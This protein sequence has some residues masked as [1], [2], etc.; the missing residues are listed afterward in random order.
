MPEKFSILELLNRNKIPSPVNQISKYEEIGIED[1]CSEIKNGKAVVPYNP[2]HS[3]EKACIIG[4]RFLVKVNANLGLSP[5]YSDVDNELKKLQK[6]LEAGADCVMDLSTGPKMDEVRKL[7]IENSPVPVGTVPVYEA[8]YRAEE[9]Y[10]KLS[11]KHIIDTIL[12]HA[13][14]GVDFM[15]LHAGLL[16]SH[17]KLAEK[18][19]MGIVSR[20]GMIIARWMMLKNEENPFYTHW[21]EIM[22]ICREYEITVSLGDGLR[23]GCI[24]D[25][26]DTAQFAELEILAELVK[27]CHKNNVQV[28]VE[29]PGH[30]PLNQIE[31]NIRKE[32]ELCNHAPF[33]VLGPVVTDIAPGY[34]HI[35]GA[36]GAAMAGWYGASLLCYVTPSEHLG[37]PDADDVYQGIIAFKIAAHAADIAR[38]NPKAKLK[39]TLMAE[40]RRKFDWQTQFALAI[41][42]KTASKIYCKS[43][44]KSKQ[45]FC[46]MC[47]E[48]FCALKSSE[49]LFKDK[50][51]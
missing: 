26:S 42:G 16:K 13:H 21:D 5:C 29:G 24:E 11:F 19:K 50:K 12:S 25:A 43:N 4:E 30:I 17:V 15:T 48:K 20:G 18:R 35:V 28:M 1:I 41:D 49:E 27:L 51:F 39:D 7:I 47:G 36:I 9:S 23:P 6:A 32:Q 38:K 45:N 10:E 46:S 40:A 34:D 14:D 22:D 3:P 33:Y 37:L 2:I 31:M 44:R 8:F